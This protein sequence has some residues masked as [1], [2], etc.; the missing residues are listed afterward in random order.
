MS[1]HSSKWS[2]TYLIGSCMS[3]LYEMYCGALLKGKKG[4][5]ACLASFWERVESSLW[6]RKRYISVISARFHATRQNDQKHGKT[7][8][9][10]Q[11]KNETQWYSILE[12][13]FDV[14][15]LCNLPLFLFLLHFDVL[16]YPLLNRHTA[17]WNL[18]VLYNKKLKYTEKK[19]FND[20][21]IYTSI[22][23]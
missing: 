5:V 17:T 20:D 23:Q 7:F 9:E 13:F 2:K 12:L 21:V 14:G 4:Y 8:S 15:G 18:F 16:C 11:L 3:C 1:C 22:L 10:Q 6:I 19:S